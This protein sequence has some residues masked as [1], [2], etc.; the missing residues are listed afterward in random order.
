[1]DKKEDGTIDDF[2]D[3]LMQQKSRRCNMYLVLVYI[4][5]GMGI[6]ST[7]YFFYQIPFMIQKQVYKCQFTELAT[8]SQDKNFADICTVENICAEDPRIA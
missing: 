2:V 4:A 1:M 8:T 5:I 7:G 6:G 3:D